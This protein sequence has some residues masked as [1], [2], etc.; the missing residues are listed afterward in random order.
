[1][2]GCHNPKRYH[3]ICLSHPTS[4][5]SGFAL[6]TTFPGALCY[7]SFPFRKVASSCPFLPCAWGRSRPREIEYFLL[8]TDI[9]WQGHPRSGVPAF[10]PLAFIC[11]SAKGVPMVSREFGNPIFQGD[12]IGLYE[13]SNTIRRQSFHLKDS[14]TPGRYLNYK[15]WGCWYQRQ[16]AN[17]SSL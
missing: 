11:L 9:R 5:V 8:Y 4:W 1:M 14:C 16:L 7:C 3:L 6:G 10:V 13:T 12:D 2:K 17:L 15:G